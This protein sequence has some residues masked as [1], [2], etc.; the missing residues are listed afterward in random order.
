M[1]AEVIPSPRLDLASFWADPQGVSLLAW[2]E[3]C[4]VLSKQN[5][6]GEVLV[7]GGNSNIFDVKAT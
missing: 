1:T 7:E 6:M 2:L 3:I 4:G 5:V